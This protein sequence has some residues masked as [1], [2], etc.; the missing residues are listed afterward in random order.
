MLQSGKTAR[1]K[2][3]LIIGRRELADFPEFKLYGIEVKVDTG[4]YTSSIHCTEIEEKNGKIYCRFS[5]LGHPDYNHKELV[6]EKYTL[7]LVKSSNGS[8]ENRYKIQTL[9][10][11][12][13][14]NYKIELTLTDRSEM[15]FPVLLGRKFLSKKFIV[16][17]TLKY[18]NK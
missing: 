2:E 6:F 3:K 13:Q 12:F 4:A 10:R 9:I 8:V 11:I 14:T 18:Q 7:K 5:D 16:D 1:K 17:V 15:K